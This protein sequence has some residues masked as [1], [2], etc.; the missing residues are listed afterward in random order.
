MVVIKK[1][2][3][4]FN[5]KAFWQGD[6]FYIAAS[7]HRSH[8]AEGLADFVLR[9]DDTCSL[10]YFQT[11]GSEGIPKWVGLTRAAFLASARA[12]N[13]H[14]EATDKD[15]WLVALPLHHVG[16]FSIFARCHA[17]GASFVQM[18]EKWNAQKF[19]QLCVDDKTTLTSLVPTQVFDLVKENTQAPKSLRAVVVGGGALA[20]DI[21]TRA[22]ELGWPLLQSYGM[23]ET[24]SQIA[25]EPLDHLYV[26][27]DPDRLE[28]L[29]IWDLQMDA[30][31]RLTVRGA[32]LASGYV[33]KSNAGWQWQ[34]L[35]AV[36]G[37]QT[38]D[39]AALWQHG[40]RRFLR[41]IGREASF[42]KIKG[43][44]V[45][46]MSLQT[47]L[48][49]LLQRRSVRGIIIIWPLPDA[50]SETK[51]VLVG[52]SCV[53]ELRVLQAS[54]NA[55]AAGFEHLS[56]VISVT[57]IP[58]SDLGKVDAAAMRSLLKSLAASQA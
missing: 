20:K 35:N 52:E 9:S 45:N 29:P 50:R 12:V 30:D 13:V 5:N 32:A 31:D 51:L 47:R 4:A 37:L 18:Q 42:V 54:F 8:G 49:A 11:S 22:M 17:N 40:T 26:G 53:E 34:P 14:L 56:D 21:G 15:R 23:T 41:M 3:S 6:D 27:F 2:L 43:E 28:V 46:V 44:L 7:P 55:T 36:T 10:L 19:A 16:G 58:R 48:D 33:L 57:Q 25:T 39:F 24:A 1:M 38:R